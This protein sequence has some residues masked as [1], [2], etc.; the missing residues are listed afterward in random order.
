M[1]KIFLRCVMLSF[2]VLLYGTMFIYFFILKLQKAY[3]PSSDMISHLTSLTSGMSKI[4]PYGNATD[5]LKAQK[6]FS[7][8]M[9]FFSLGKPLIQDRLNIFIEPQILH[10]KLVRLCSKCGS[11]SYISGRW[12]V[13][14]FQ[15][16]FFII[17][18]SLA[19]ATFII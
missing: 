4:R 8:S 13:E 19:L 5:V 2:V 11:L 9:E 1:F 18:L 14:L 16:V 17:V 12:I 10:V 15:V 7:R 3:L 6:Y